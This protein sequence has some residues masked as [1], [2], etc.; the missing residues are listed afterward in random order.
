MRVYVFVASTSPYL[1]LFH[2]GYLRL[3]MNDYKTGKKRK[4]KNIINGVLVQQSLVM[5]IDYFNNFF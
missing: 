2:P 5:E 3:S 1:V 4:G